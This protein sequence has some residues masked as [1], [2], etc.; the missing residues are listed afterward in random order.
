MRTALKRIYR[1]V[2]TFDSEVRTIVAMVRRGCAAAKRAC[3]VLDVGC[4]YGRNLRVLQASGFSAVGVDANPE[5]VAANR[6]DGLECLTAQELA[7]SER[8]F[9][10]ILMSHVI[11]HLAPHELVPFMDGYLDRLDTGGRLV[12]ATPLLTAYFYDDFDHVK[13]YHPMGILMVFGADRAQVQYYARNR[14]ALEDVWIRRSPIRLG[15][16]RSRYM[17]SWQTRARQAAELIS[18]LAFRGSFGIIGQSDGWVGLFQK[19]G[20]TPIA[21]QGTGSAG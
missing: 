21:G 2:V 8:R 3:R 11:E 7:E 1:A 17:L 12:I 4:G 15:H 20:P 10:V 14:L 13:P 19:L 9:D 18:A 16:A 6:K 5:I